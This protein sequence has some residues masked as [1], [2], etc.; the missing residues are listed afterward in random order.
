MAGRRT[1][2][3][4]GPWSLARECPWQFALV[5]SSA[6]LLDQTKNL[7]PCIIFGR[8]P[9]ADDCPLSDELLQFLLIQML[10]HFA[11]VLGVFASGHQ[12]SVCGLDYD[13][14]VDANNGY[15]LPRR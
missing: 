11:H 8:R 3:V 6:N 2:L 9:R 10:Y 7:F 5:A 15:K 14:I 4:V 13:R 12:Q 1:S